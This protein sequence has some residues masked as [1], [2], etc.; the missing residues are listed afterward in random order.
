MSNTSNSEKLHEEQKE[1]EGKMEE[2]MK[3]QQGMGC[4]NDNQGEAKKL[5]GGI[6]KCSKRKDQL[7]WHVC[8]VQRRQIFIPAFLSLI[9]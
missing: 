9:K 8:K 4:N 7:V 1:E 6:T 5:K 3:S 2:D